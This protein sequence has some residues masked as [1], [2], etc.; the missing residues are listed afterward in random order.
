MAAIHW[1]LPLPPVAGPGEAG[2]PAAC[3]LENFFRVRT[4][5]PDPESDSW[6]SLV[7]P[8]LRVLCQVT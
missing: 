8:G 1:P 4:G 3:L 7:E 2:E 6:A 5:G